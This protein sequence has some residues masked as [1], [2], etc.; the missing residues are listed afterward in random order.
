MPPQVQPMGYAA[1][2]LGLGGMLQDQ[3]AGETEEQRKKRM[4]QMQQRQMMGPVGTPATQMLF[5]GG[6]RSGGRGAG[7]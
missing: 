4:L 2:D 6:L 7:Y 1:A 3:V 5:G